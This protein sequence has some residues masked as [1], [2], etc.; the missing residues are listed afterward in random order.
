MSHNCSIGKATLSE[1]NLF[2]YTT[3]TGLKDIES[4]GLDER[5][6][7]SWRSGLNMNQLETVCFHHEQVFM[8]RFAFLQK[9]CCDPFKSHREK[10]SRSSLRE[11]SLSMA[12]IFQKNEID[13]I[14]GQ[15]ICP[16]CRIKYNGLCNYDIVD[17]VDDQISN[18]ELQYGNEQATVKETLSTSL[19]ELEVSPIKLHAIA[20]HSRRAY[21][22]RKFNEVKDKLHKKELT[23]QKSLANIIN[24]STELLEG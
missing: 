23:L 3:R 5:E 20:C 6:V 4:F 2:T 10:G 18:D 24:I 13:V 22:K 17:E 12:R 9:K 21:G 16:K 14:P 8:E 7:L 1:C 15:K 19:E 11:I